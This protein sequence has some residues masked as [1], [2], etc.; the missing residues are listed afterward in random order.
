MDC[1]RLMKESA[2]ECR[3]QSDALVAEVL[4][5][6]VIGTATR[7]AVT[8]VVA[9]LRNTAKRL[10]GFAER[11]KEE[12]ALLHAGSVRFGQHGNHVNYRNE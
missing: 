6:G 3:R 2:E 5:G 12:A 1:Y 7:T 8:D 10:D 4:Q 9:V 11:R